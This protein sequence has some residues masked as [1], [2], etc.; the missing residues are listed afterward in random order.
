MP[1]F[2]RT[3]AWLC[4]TTGTASSSSHCC[5]ALA[6]SWLRGGSRANSENCLL[7]VHPLSCCDIWHGG[8]PGA[9]QGAVA[10]SATPDKGMLMFVP[11]RGGAADGIFDFGPGLE[12]AALQ[13]QRAQNLPPRLD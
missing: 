1:G 4:A 12:A 3:S 13:R 7:V 10:P 2:W 8:D 6:Y 5:R 9:A 11:V